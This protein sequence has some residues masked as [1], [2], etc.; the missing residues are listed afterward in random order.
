MARRRKRCQ[1]CNDLFHSRPQ[2]KGKQ[3]FCARPACQKERKHLWQRKKRQEDK[4][5]RENDAA[6]QK[7]WAKEHP[8]Y[9]QNYREKMPG[10][11]EKNRVKQRTRNHRRKRSTK[12]QAR[13]P[14]TIELNGYSYTLNET[15]SRES[16]LRD[17]G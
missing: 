17:K 16:P 5:Y 15:R 12:G 2:L 10:Y 3:T 8:N 6:A 1:G 7:E 9:W 4:A 13:P 14:H 11:T